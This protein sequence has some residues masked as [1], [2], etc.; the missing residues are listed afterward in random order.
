M[1]TRDAPGAGRATA[2]PEIRLA[3][4]TWTGA[5]TVSD[6]PPRRR[7]IDVTRF[8]F[9]AKLLRQESTRQPSMASGWPALGCRC[10]MRAVACWLLR[11]GTPAGSSA[12]K[13]WSTPHIVQSSV[14]GHDR[15]VM[16][17]RHKRRRRYGPGDDVGRALEFGWATLVNWTDPRTRR[18]VNGHYF[19][20]SL[21]PHSL[22]VSRGDLATRCVPIRQG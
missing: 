18:A 4:P 21:N 8:G 22:A 17:L 5:G 19:A 14:W 2:W 1:G 16:N 7:P 10:S 20:L 3:R 13:S 9:A 11:I 12:R 15:E 6:R